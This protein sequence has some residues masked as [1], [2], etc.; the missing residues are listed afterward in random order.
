MY[1]MNLPTWRDD[2]A[3]TGAYAQETVDRLAKDLAALADST[4]D[5]P[6]RWGLRQALFHR[7]GQTTQSVKGERR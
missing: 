7:T 3:I 1:G 4:G 6:V 5:P 2:P